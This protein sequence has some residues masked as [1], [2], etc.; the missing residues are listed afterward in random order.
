[1]DNGQT[2]KPNL[3][4]YARFLRQT[5]QRRGRTESSLMCNSLAFTNFAIPF[6]LLKQP[7]TSRKSRSLYFITRFTSSLLI[8]LIITES[9][10][11]YRAADHV[12]P[13]YFEYFTEQ[14]FEDLKKRLP[15]RHEYI[16]KEQ[17]KVICPQKDN[18]DKYVVNLVTY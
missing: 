18:G 13:E 2:Q 12:N 8:C 5:I 14:E 7:V 10:L 16:P 17:F 6:Y 3:S 4:P 9:I 15:E 1:M 11:N